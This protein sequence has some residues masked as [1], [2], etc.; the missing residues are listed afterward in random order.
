MKGSVN[1]KW[2]RRFVLFIL[3]G[4]VSVGGTLLSQVV[5]SAT[6]EKSLTA[7]P[8]EAKSKPGPA[9][10]S[11][12]KVFAEDLS[13]PVGWL[14]RGGIL[15]TVNGPAYITPDGERIFLSDMLV[16]HGRPRLRWLEWRKVK[17][18]GSKVYKEISCSTPTSPRLGAIFTDLAFLP[19]RKEMLAIACHRLYL[20]DSS[21]LDVKRVLLDGQ[22][23]GPISVAADNSRVLVQAS[24][25]HGINDSTVVVEGA[26]EVVALATSTWTVEES[27]KLPGKLA[28]L[29]ITGDGKSAVLL[30]HATNDADS[31]CVLWIRDFPFSAS[32]T[33]SLP[34]GHTCG[35]SFYRKLLPAVRS[36]PNLIIEP[37]L[38]LRVWDV[39]KGMLV[40]QQE[41]QP[42]GIDEKEINDF[43][44]RISPDGGY[45]A[46]VVNSNL[47]FQEMLV[48]D[49]LSGK[50]VFE[51]KKDSY[52]QAFRGIGMVRTTAREGVSSDI[53]AD[54]R[55]VLS[56]RGKRITVFEV[57]E[58]Q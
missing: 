43:A 31:N 41:L 5:S 1:N 50:V 39:R 2:P 10:L 22:V 15:D 3:W 55:F 14:L 58:L 30:L 27:W 42:P 57:A 38:L 6:S 46:L 52:S 24:G 13:S 16:N 9:K 40:R 35:P 44:F 4:M 20:L 23:M 54:G 11:V 18:S 26:D 36:D 25:A 17:K 19:Q 32:E 47:F 48:I 45:V 53:S 49:T 29:G 37:S 21:T 8:S 28:G 33:R 34:T 12:R 51:G 56:A 7:F